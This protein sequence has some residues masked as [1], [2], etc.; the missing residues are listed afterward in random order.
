MKSFKQMIKTG[1]VRRADAM[2]IRIEDL[3]EE[4]GFNLR[5]AGLVGD[6][7]K[8]FE[9]EVEDLANYIAAGGQVPPLEVRP[10]EEGGAWIV[11][12]HKRSR[13]FRKL[14]KD[15]Q[16]PRDPKTGE[17]LISVVPFVGNDADRTARIITSQEGR[18][19]MPI[20]LAIGYKRLAAFGWTADQIGKK[21][22]K[23]R[24]HVDQMLLLSNAN[25]DVQQLVAAGSIAAAT[26]VEM[27]RT[28]GEQAGAVIAAGLKQAQAAGKTKVTAKTLKPKREK[29]VTF[30]LV[31]HLRRQYDFS[32]RT[33]GPGQRTTGVLDHIRKELTEVEAN[34]GD[35]YK[36]A[37]VLLLA[38]DG[39][40]R[41][42]FGPELVA[43]AIGQKQKWNE[44]RKWPDW[45]TV[46]PNKAIE[47][48]RDEETA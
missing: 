20:E 21:V 17:L 1:E 9:E 37:D 6:S 36:W 43:Q 38:L 39:A 46:D 31:A 13:A 18:K 23:T 25:A 27:V 34:P 7:G 26:A 11:D 41:A 30:D 35:I 40:M 4:P 45:R 32:L 12:G 28:H 3:Y 5:I 16:I 24:Q 2:K 22:G 44:G 48:E 42:G 15:G 14:D 29:V 19:L 10:R 8:T 33:F 47:H